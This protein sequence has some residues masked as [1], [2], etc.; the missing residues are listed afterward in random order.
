[1]VRKLLHLLRDTAAR[2]PAII[3]AYFIYLYYFF[4]TLDFYKSFKAA[5]LASSEF[6][7]HFDALF[8]MWLLA[9]AFVKVL[10]YREKSHLHEKLMI[11]Q[12][13]QAREAEWRCDQYQNLTTTLKT[14]VNEPVVIASGYLRLIRQQYQNGNGITSKLDAVDE[15]LKKVV[16]GLDGFYSKI[17]SVE[18]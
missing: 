12:E 1:M 14:E 3:S 17:K 13:Q 11:I 9:F 5:H 4:V 15:Q 8:W 10:A 7:T 16:R 2:Y 18:S 6:L